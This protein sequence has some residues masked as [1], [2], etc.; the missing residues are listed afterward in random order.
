M[1]PFRAAL[2]ALVLSIVLLAVVG[3]TAA[4]AT[5]GLATQDASINPVVQPTAASP[6]A[7]AG[8]T[9][10]VQAGDNL[11]RI[12]LKFGLTVDI[13]AKAN[14]IVNTNLVYVGQTLTIPAGAVV[15]G[16]TSAVA[17]V[18]PLATVPTVATQ[19]GAT[20]DAGIINPNAP[21]TATRAPVAPPSSGGAGGTY[22][23]QAGDNLYRISLKFNTNMLALMQLNNIAN[24][25]LIYVG[26][27]L[28]LPGGAQNP[29][30]STP[31]PG[32]TAAPTPSNTASNVGFT[33]GVTV[34]LTGQDANALTASAKDLGMSWV[35]VPVSWRKMEIAKG[36]IDSTSLDPQIDALS[37][38]GVK[39]LLT[40]S[41][42]PDWARTSNAESG[43]PTDFKDYANFIGA[44]AARYKGKVQAYEV[45]DEPNLRR[46]W[47][48]RPLSAASY[49][50][51]LRLAFNAIKL[52]DPAA[53]VVSAGLS[54]TGYNDGV[55]AINDRAFLR[56]AYTAGL[57]SYSDAIGV[58]P[59]GWANPPDSTCCT[60][61]PGVSGWFNDRSFYFR[62]TLTDYRTIMAQNG[63]GGTF[64]WITDF[65]WGSSEGVVADPSTVDSN[66][67]FVNFTSQA[68]QAQYIPR[69]YE[70]ART[71]G[72]VG[73]MFLYNLNYCQTVTAP[74]GS[75]EFRGCY[76]SLLNIDGKP[77]PAYDALKAAPK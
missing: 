31:A 5:L 24:A 59:E 22:T 62:D 48:G 15:A 49:V 66:F 68:A 6:S 51:M 63:D 2:T 73:P 75:S 37:S 52:A 33:F 12:A 74:I 13:L 28:T 42:A 46:N 53:L 41:S 47:N 77:R 23:V 69:A 39:V 1:R 17:T 72:Y 60:A 61:S 32:G 35:K 44:L 45:W 55:N 16:P 14:G 71:L 34:D 27:V 25:N 7:G 56:Q 65:G 26:Q 54:P 57:G 18:V 20:T 38:N 8:G 76:Y 58:D 36:N 19:P 9:Y 29:G 21:P 11:Y 30:G 67:G 43:P 40:V 64:L 50:E 4:T 70:L 3:P 10:V